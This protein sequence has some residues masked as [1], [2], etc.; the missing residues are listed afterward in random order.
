MAL[1]LTQ[2]GAFRCFQGTFALSTTSTGP[3]DYISIAPDAYSVSVQLKVLD[4]AIATIEATCNTVEE[5]TAGLATWVAWD[6]GS[7]TGGQTKQD[8]AKSP[9]GAIR[10]QVLTAAAGNNAIVSIRTLGEQL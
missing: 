4:G 7:V 9:I 6:A 10:V 2:I 1:N 5:I 8:T 3:S